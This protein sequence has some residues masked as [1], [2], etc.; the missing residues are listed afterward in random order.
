[1][2]IVH[3]DDIKG[4]HIEAPYKREIKHLSAPWTLGSK[5]LW[6]GTSTVAP[7]NKTNAHSHETNEEVFYCVSGNGIMIVDDEE[8]EYRQGNLVY[9]PPGCVHQVVN[10]GEV[11]LKSL[12]SVSPPFEEKQFRDDHDMES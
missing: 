12:C 11:P 10:T 5:N 9:V 3:E 7:G 1:M 8:K 4:D 6:I 2:H